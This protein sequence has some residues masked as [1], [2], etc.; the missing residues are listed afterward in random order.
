MAKEKY[1]SRSSEQA[2]TISPAGTEYTNDY[3]IRIDGNNHKTLVKVGKHNHYNEI[4]SYL[5]ETK[6]ENILAKAALGD[7]TALNVT[8][9]KYMDCLDMPKTLAEAQQTILNI[10]NE[11]ESLPLEVREK[12]NFSPEEYV[13]NYGTDEWSTKV[14]L[15]QAIEETSTE[16]I[17]IEEKNVKEKSL[18]E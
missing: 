7:T 13:A 12:F 11:F 6:I 3:E 2:L 10:K 9:G 1:R 4:Q 18:N 14:G 5:E 8:E 15:I 17:T 16:E